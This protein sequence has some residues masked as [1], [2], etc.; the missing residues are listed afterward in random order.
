MRQLTSLDAQFLNA[1]SGTTVAH[2]G[3]VVLVDP[4][5]HDGEW[6][7]DAVRSVYEQ[8]LHLVPL[9]RQ[10]LVEVPLGLGRPY[11]VDDP[12]FD[13]EFHLRELA[14]PSPGNR[15]QLG[16]QVARI[17]ARPL[18]RTRP[19]WEAY[20][21]TGLEDGKAAFYTKVHHAAIDGVSG[22]EILET[23]LDVTVEPREVPPEEAAP[24]GDRVP[25]PLDMLVRGAASL[26][27]S[28]VDIL[29]TVPKSLSYLDELPGAANFPGVRLLSGAAS[30]V[31]RLVGQ[32][33]HPAGR[34]LHAPRTPFNGQITAHRRFGFGSVPLDDV[35][36]VKNHLGMTVNDVVMTMTASALRRWL[37]DHDALPRVPLVAAVPVSIRT[38]DQRGSHGNEVSVMIAELPTHLGGALERAE[39][40]R[41]AMQE[42]KQHF[43]AAPPSLYQDLSTVIPTAL[44][45]QV[46]RTLFRAA[47]VPGVLFNLFVSN[48]P[49]P[50]LPLYLAGARV[51]GLY[52]A[53]AVTDWT[54][55]LNITLFSYDGHLDF[56][57]I[58]C[59]EMVPD[60]WNLVRYLAEALDELVALV[61]D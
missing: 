34:D 40:T 10:R 30:T 28:P 17:H 8:R 44:S 13:I 5:S 2:V 25:S 14:L 3:S 46:A 54:G 57:L 39:A 35:K 48:I 33:R 41:D 55:G 60:V 15:E 52:P 16:E 23:I 43:Q 9:L 21:I 42:A 59:R 38:E 6:G 32:S 29:R 24:A 22:E 26:A 27:T 12:H 37:L 36:R 11:W 56:G 18:D 31:G 20:V 49:G 1:E 45:G 58:A 50:Q 19:L 47:T 51:E 61:P 53:S 7:L 4:S